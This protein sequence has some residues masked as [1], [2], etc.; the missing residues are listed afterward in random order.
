MFSTAFTSRPLGKSF[1]QCLV[2]INTCWQ[3]AIFHGANWVGQKNRFTKSLLGQCSWRNGVVYNNVTRRNLG[4]KM[5]QTYSR[6]Q[7]A[8]FSCAVSTSARPAR[9]G[10]I[11]DSVAFICEAICRHSSLLQDVGSLSNTSQVGPIGN[12]NLEFLRNSKSEPAR[13]AGCLTESFRYERSSFHSNAVPLQPVLFGFYVSG[14]LRSR[15]VISCNRTFHTPT[16]WTR[17]D[18]IP[19]QGL[20]SQKLLEVGI[21]SVR[22]HQMSSDVIRCHP[23]SS[24]FSHQ[25][26]QAL[27]WQA[28]AAIYM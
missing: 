17:S 8:V 6:W 9:D 20:A 19:L 15:M 23:M 21:F 2:C 25:T 10:I 13:S 7:S 27:R 3:E 5:L 1:Q 14:H 24:V 22:R 4:F 16:T 26:H 12:E 11:F 28:E 18:R